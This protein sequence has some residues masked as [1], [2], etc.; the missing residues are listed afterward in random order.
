VGSVVTVLIDQELG[1]Q[2]GV[3]V[4]DHW[5]ET[6]SGEPGWLARGRASPPS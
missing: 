1:G 5:R 6:M 4:G 2:S 3:A